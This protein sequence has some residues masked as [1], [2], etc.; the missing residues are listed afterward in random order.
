MNVIGMKVTIKQKTKLGYQILCI[1]HKQFSV[2]S[3]QRVVSLCLV[4][5]AYHPISAQQ[6]K[7]AE[8]K[9]FNE[10]QAFFVNI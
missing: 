3:L 10:K 7:I 4:P 6:A 5:W 1:K 8:V 2:V 9:T